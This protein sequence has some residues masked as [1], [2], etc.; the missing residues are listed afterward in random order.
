[1]QM[2]PDGIWRR[3]YETALLETDEDKV[4]QS[5]EDAVQAIDDRREDALQGRM[6]LDE[7]ERRALD[8]ASRTL[9]FLQQER[10]A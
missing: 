9:R 5:I 3:F 7:R 2:L 1:M 6:P 4:S 8:D 10:A